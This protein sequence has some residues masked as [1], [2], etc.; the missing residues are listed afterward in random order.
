MEFGSTVWNTGYLGDLRLLESVQRHWT[1]HIDG[2]ADLSCTGR[3]KALNLYVLCTGQALESWS[4]QMLE[5]FPQSIG[6]LL[7]QLPCSPFL[8]SLI[9]EVTELNKPNQTPT[10]SVD[11]DSSVLGA[12]TTGTP[13]QTALLELILLRHLNEA[14][15]SRLEGY[16]LLTLSRFIQ[17][18]LSDLCTI[19]PHLTLSCTW[20]TILPIILCSSPCSC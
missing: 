15:T 7:T 6:N 17:Y 9:P 1:K 3:L 8:L 20:H 10:Q 2:L 18:L 12:L 5:D 14:Y 16:C 13:S 4:Y 19:Y 11:I